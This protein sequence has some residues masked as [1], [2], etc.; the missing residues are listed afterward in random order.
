MKPYV[1]MKNLNDI[2]AIYTMN[3]II[4]KQ[5]ES[6]GSNDERKNIIK[7]KIVQMIAS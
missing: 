4:Q 7:E 2:E 6:V 1:D 3:N 5:S